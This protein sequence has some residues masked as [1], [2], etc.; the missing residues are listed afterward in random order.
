MKTRTKVI[1]LS[2]IILVLVVGSVGT[3]YY[4][5][6]AKNFVTSA[7]DYKLTARVFF[8]EFMKDQNAAAA[9]YVIRDKTIQ[10]NGKISEIKKGNDGSVTIT[11]DCGYPDGDISCALTR[12]ESTKANALKPGAPVTI[13]GE[14]TGYEELINKEVV[15]IRCGIID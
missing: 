1:S 8:E 12:E 2:F 9:K 5:K 3:Y 7:A 4:F 10:L 15:M 13:K 11:L 14:C 6:P